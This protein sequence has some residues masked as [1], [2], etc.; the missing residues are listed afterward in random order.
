MIKNL[1]SFFKKFGLPFL[2]ILASFLLVKSVLAAGTVDV[3]ASQI[4]SALSLG[5]SSPFIIVTRII[6]IALGF[7]GLI[8]VSIFIYAGFLWMTSGGSEEKISEAKRMLRNA[9]IGIII[10]LS[11]WGIAYFVLSKLVGVTGGT[12]PGGDLN[13]GSL[14]NLSLGAIGSCSIESVYPQPDSKD[15][16]RNSAI[17]VTAKEALQLDTICINKVSQN[18]CACDN[19]PNCNLINPANIQIYK[20]SDGNSC[21]SGSCETNVK[22]VEVTVPSDKKTIVLRPL[23]YLG[24]S[25]GN[26][27]YGVRLTNSIKKASGE[28]LFT[29]C[30]SDFLEWTFETSSKLDLEPPQVVFGENFPP[31]D[32]EADIVSS[33][34]GAKAAQAKIVVTA[35]PKT[36]TPAKVIGIQKLGT[37]ID[38]DIIADPNYSGVITDFTVNVVSK[39]KMSLYSGSGLLGSADVVNNEAVFSGYFTVKVNDEIPGNSWTVIVNPAAAAETLTLSSDTYIFVNQKTNGGNEIV[40]PAD[41]SSS[42]S[43]ADI[44]ANIEVALSGNDSVNTTSS[45][46]TLTLFSKVTGLSGNSLTLQS[47]SQGL[48]I[49]KFAG[50]IEKSE[51][52]TIKGLK[53]KPMNSVIQ[54]NFN[55]AMNPMVLSGSADELKN[56]VKLVNASAT[57]KDNGAPCGNDNECLSYNC[58]A[59]ACVGSYVS[60]KYALSNAYKTMEFV[61]DKECGVNSC[62][63]TMY[64]LPAGSHLALKINAAT[65]K[66]CSASSDCQ[67]FAPYSECVAGACKNTATQTYYP[68]A[69]SLNLNGAVDLAFNSLDGNRDNKA[70]GPVLVPYPY[71]IEGGSDKSKRDGFQFSFFISNEINSTPPS[72]SLASPKL[73]ETNVMI[74]SPVI[75]DFNDLMMNSTLGTGSLSIN[76]GLISTEH[77]LINLRN[78]AN[79]PLGYWVVSEAKEIGTPNGEPDY[80]SANIMHSDFF[81][82]VT[83]IS[84]IG[85]GVKNIY[86]NCFKPSVGPGCVSLSE[87]NPSCCFGSATNALD[88]NGNCAN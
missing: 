39:D 8:V 6:N 52:Y 31:V 61:S 62:G 70:D 51:T 43:S 24:T 41:C 55:E 48:S 58:Q 78:S 81:E 4:D 32:N 54:V 2:A 5:N 59:T 82:S 12:P 56:Y 18:P 15:V 49:Q 74:S 57:A 88:S 35:C 11:A 16:A 33:S 85:S 76:N 40:V 42:N 9:I 64:C 36:Y 21:V 17:L 25:S 68:L 80:T 65:L 50:G 87:A 10:T 79:K 69:D 29:T 23:N 83:Y 46:G 19:T 73:A 1:T 75:I 53:D 86:Q 7:L 45:G 34:S 60:G 66:P 37:S 26:V 28:A 67:V 84:Q 27:E 63:E 14:K 71:Y 3:G 30:S 13:N 38:A 20:T 77:K 47:T 44:A 22:D 72:I